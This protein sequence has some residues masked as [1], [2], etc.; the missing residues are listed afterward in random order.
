MIIFLKHKINIMML[1]KY[2]KDFK[3][4][5]IVCSNKTLIKGLVTP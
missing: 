2:N 5:K 3:K 4:K 1:K